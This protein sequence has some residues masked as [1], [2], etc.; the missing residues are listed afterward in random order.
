MPLHPAPCTSYPCSACRRTRISGL[1]P[2]STFCRCITS[3]SCYYIDTLSLQVLAEG[4]PAWLG[5]SYAALMFAGT[6][7]GVLADNQHFQRVMRAGFRLKAALAAAVHRQVGGR[8]AV[9]H[10]A[11]CAATNYKQTTNA[12]LAVTFDFP[13]SSPSL[14]HVEE[15]GWVFGYVWQ[16]NPRTS[17]PLSTPPDPTT[18]TATQGA[19][20]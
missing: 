10:A 16:A 13:M 9:R 7:A 2:H 14:I 4:G 8:E 5:Y 20:C 19:K 15:H 1:R 12:V 18:W 6:A 17:S 3:C 11:T